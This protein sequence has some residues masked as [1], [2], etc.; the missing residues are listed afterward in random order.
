MLGLTRA[1]EVATLEVRRMAAHTLRMHAATPS[2]SASGVQPVKASPWQGAESP[3]VLAAIAAAPWPLWSVVAALGVPGAEHVPAASHGALAFA[4]VLAV[5]GIVTHRPR[6]RSALRWSLAVLGTGLM[7]ELLAN[8]LTD[9]GRS[10]GLGGASDAQRALVVWLLCFAVYEVAPIVAATA[11]I[12]RTE[13]RRWPV[14]AVAHAVFAAAALGAYAWAPTWGTAWFVSP[15]MAVA[16]A[17]PLAAARSGPDR[18]ARLAA[19][20]PR[21]GV[22]FAGALIGW[23]LIAVISVSRT[24]A[25]SASLHEMRWGASA[26]DGVLLVFPALSLLLSLIA[27]GALLMRARSARRGTTGQVVELG[28]GGATIELGGNAPVLVAVDAGP[29]PPAGVTVTLLGAVEENPGAGPFRDGAPQLRVRRL[30]TGRP[31]ALA[32]SLRHRAAAWLVWG[33]VCALGV[34]LRLL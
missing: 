27:A 7:G 9:M 23:A 2:S 5:M 3:W 10:P 30:W 14:D 33:A 21:G 31:E 25:I 26:S 22:L 4:L 34:L 15:W 6:F 29:L 17:L 1:A 12:S 28:D 13:R 8:A 20:H 19:P 11:R 32:R 16:V 24:T 18:P